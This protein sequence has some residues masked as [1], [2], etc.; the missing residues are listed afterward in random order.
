MRA[1]AAA[2]V[3]LVFSVV[4]TCSCF[5]QT[6]LTK[7]SG[8]DQ[9]EQ[10]FARY[11]KDTGQRRSEF[12]KPVVEIANGDALVTFRL[13]SLDDEGVIVT[14]GKNGSE[15]ISPNVPSRDFPK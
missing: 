7:Q 6:A 9:A 5:S 4:L 13:L 1:A 15:G 3:A 11:L 12:G 2:S 14:L 8:V 10:L